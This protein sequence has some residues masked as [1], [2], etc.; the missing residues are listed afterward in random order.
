MDDAAAAL[1]DL[2]NYSDYTPADAGVGVH[3][4]SD[5]LSAHSSAHHLADKI[6]NALCDAVTAVDHL[7]CAS[8]VLETIARADDSAHSQDLRTEYAVAA[9][10]IASAVHWAPVLARRAELMAI[11]GQK[12]FLVTR[13][14]A[15]KARVVVRKTEIWL[16]GIVKDIGRDLIV[17]RRE[18]RRVSS[19]DS[20]VAL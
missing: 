12:R 19:K 13:D 8:L 6:A 9:K 5:D 10:E 7:K 11:F 18:V 14:S 15:K 17:A 20:L 3:A 1:A 4:A 16:K 2:T